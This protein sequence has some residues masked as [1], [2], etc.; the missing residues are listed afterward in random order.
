[1]RQR[2]LETQLTTMAEAS[3]LFPICCLAL[4]FLFIVVFYNASVKECVRTFHHNTI[5]PT[6]GWI[7][8]NASQ[9]NES[10]APEQ[11]YEVIDTTEKQEDLSEKRDEH[12]LSPERPWFFPRSQSRYREASSS[13]YGS[14]PPDV[15]DHELNSSPVS[16]L[17][18]HSNSPAPSETGSDIDDGRSDDSS[19]YSEFT[20]GSGDGWDN[21]SDASDV[22]FAPGI[23]RFSVSND[24]F[25]PPDVWQIEF[26]ETV[27]S[28]DR[29]RMGMLDRAVHWTAQASFAIVAPP[30]VLA[31]IEERYDWSRYVEG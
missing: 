17:L 28:E 7:K 1:M 22:S 4:S 5:L 16:P 9:T 6:Y 3:L 15:H 20:V 10:I 30:A 29:R 13:S 2:P 14:P 19:T 8:R 25:R 18:S 27:A 24:P 12:Q 23:P 11:A 31:A 21:A 26:E